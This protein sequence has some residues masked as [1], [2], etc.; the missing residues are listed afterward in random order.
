MYQLVILSA[1]IVVALIVV[2]TGKNLY[3]PMELAAKI[4]VPVV[5]GIVCISIFN[6]VFA[7]LDFKLALN[8]VTAATA[9]YLGIPGFVALI[10]I[11]LLIV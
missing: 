4:L 2:Y 1:V 11:K 7:P 10:V 6:V 8:P 5:V 3:K 9:G